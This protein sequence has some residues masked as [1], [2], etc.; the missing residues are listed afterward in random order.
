[1]EVLQPFS[2]IWILTRGNPERIRVDDLWM[3][4]F[5]LL[6]DIHRKIKLGVFGLTFSPMVGQNECSNGF[7]RFSRLSQKSSSREYSISREK[8]IWINF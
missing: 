2:Y 4:I 6:V 3:K 1:M 8:I 7:S 5:G